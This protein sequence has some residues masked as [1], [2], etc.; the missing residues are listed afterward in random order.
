MLR[1]AIAL[2][3]AATLTHA[4]DRRP[5]HCIAIA[6]AAPGLRYLHKAAWTDPLPDYTVR[7]HYIAHA[8][9]LLQ[10]PGGLSA[11]TD[12]AGSVGP[13]RFVPDVVT[14]NHAHETHWTSAPDSRIPHVLPG[15]G[16]FGEGI[17]HHL[18]LGEML[19]RN[20]STD[21]RSGFT[22]AETRGNSIF[23]FEVAGLCIG[24]LGH[25]HHEPTPEQYAAIGR[26][27]V[28]MVPVDGG[29]TLDVGTMTRIVER[30][31][32]S[33][34]IPMHWFSDRALGV[35]L[36][37]VSDVFAIERVDGNDIELSLRTLPKRPTV[38]VLRPRW[39][40]DRG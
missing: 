7:L 32:S 35:F 14:M 22:G 36:D 8:S 21:I 30:L 9:F 15:W 19:I 26:L 38:M 4:Q 20:V 31:R 1:L 29:Y 10:T 40:S 27:D 39:L 24:H 25:L 18:D 34:V 5:S 33:V 6:D 11:V 16:A 13:T 2:I 12:Y 23:I 17:E 3:C 37:G 28:V